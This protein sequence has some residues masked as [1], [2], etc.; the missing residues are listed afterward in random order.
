MKPIYETSENAIELAR[1]K[2]NSEAL[3]KLYLLVEQR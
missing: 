3:E 2:R 1:L